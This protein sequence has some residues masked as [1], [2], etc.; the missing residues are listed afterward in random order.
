MIQGEKRE[1]QESQ[2]RL[3][4]GVGEVKVLAINPS[5]EEYSSVLGIELK[6]D[7]K[8]TEYLGESKDNNTTL[9]LDIWVENVKTKERDKITYFLE[10]K[11]RVNKDGTKKQYINQEGA[12]SWADDPNNLPDWFKKREYRVAYNGEEELHNFLRTWLGKLDVR[13]KGELLLE[14]KPLMKGNVKELT[15]MLGSEYETNVVVLYTVKSQEKE[16]ETKNYQSIYN[17]QLLPAYNMK[18][19]RNVDY[20][21]EEVQNALKSKKPKDLKPHEKFVVNVSNPEHGCRESFTL[22]E[23]KEFN[24]EEYLAASSKVLSDEDSSY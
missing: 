3:K 15:S 4:I 14:W 6:E 10:N 20:N 19:F 21:K 17:K 24:P 22:S 13:E 1:Q 18:F 12:C 5:T 7:S 23:M 16:G 11:E 2:K 9:R 8:A